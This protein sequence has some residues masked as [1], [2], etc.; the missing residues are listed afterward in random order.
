MQP[1]RIV[2]AFATL[3]LGS[4]LGTTAENS[5]LTFEDRVR[6]QEAIERVYYAHQIGTKVSFEKAV[7]RDVLEKK[8]RN[9]LKQSVAL[10]ESWNTPVTAEA[11]E[12]ELNRI[13]RSTRFPERLEEIYA[14]LGDDPILVQETF[15]RQSLVDRLTRSFFASDERFHAARR[16]DAELLRRRLVSGEIDVHQ[17]REGRSVIAIVQEEQSQGGT[18]ERGVVGPPSSRQSE[19]IELEK[20]GYDRWRARMPGR[21]GEIGPVVD[22]GE[23]FVVRVL[24]DEEDGRASAA[25][26]AVTKTPWIAWWAE[27]EENFHEDRARQVATAQ[28]AFSL[29]VPYTTSDAA[30]AGEEAASSLEAAGASSCP[31]DDSWDPDD[32][33]SQRSGHSAVWTGSLMIVW[34]GTAQSTG[35]RYD[36]L[37][38]SWTPTSVVDA[39]RM[40]NLSQSAVWTGS[41]MIVWTGIDGGRY[42]P[43]SDTWTPISTTNA[44]PQERVGHRAVWI[45]S[46]MVIWGGWY[47][48]P[49]A[50]YLTTGGRYDPDTDT[51][52]P[53]STTNAPLGREGQTAVWT[54]S[55]M[56]VFGGAIYDYNQHQYLYSGSGSR[57]DPV[58]DTWTQISPGERGRVTAPC[59]R[60]VR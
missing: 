15:A 22:E 39:P 11:L 29:R 27:V 37:T 20:D 45:G 25:T 54:G 55:Q 38:D 50:V 17:Q 24:L 18:I 2:L 3:L 14:A 59:G 26:Y 1:A 58:T 32:V 53:M 52:S 51:W 21:V 4:S 16:D 44:P 7:P 13:V 43:V 34:G 33:P 5:P 57:Y 6:A 10:E 48:G 36:P 30:A 28:A 47:Y 42:D 46:E 35:G 60:E 19:P 40:R 31:P 12:A 41:E 23:A 8:V 49:D 56:I 9:Y